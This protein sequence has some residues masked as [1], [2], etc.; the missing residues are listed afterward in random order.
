[1]DTFTIMAIILFIGSLIALGGFAYRRKKREEERQRQLQRLQEQQER[2]RLEREEQ[3]R[4]R[5]FQLALEQEKKRRE[6]L[7]KDTFELRQAYDD[8]RRTQGQGQ[9]A[10]LCTG[11]FAARQLPQFLTAFERAS[12][13]DHIGIILLLELSEDE[14]D[15]C[16][17]NVPTQ[18]LSRIVHP[19][20]E[21][22]PEGLNGARLAKAM[23]RQEDWWHDAETAIN[24]WLALLQH[25]TRTAVLVDIVSPGGSAILAYPATKRF[26]AVYPHA[27]VYMSTI[28]DHKPEVRF[29]FPEIRQLLCQDG[30]V[31]GTILSDNT[32]DSKRNDLGNA[33]FYASAVNAPWIDDQPSS[34]PNLGAHIFPRECHCGAAAHKY[35][36]MSVAGDTIPV[37]YVPEW[38]HVLPFVHYTKASMAVASIQ[39][40]IRT[41]FE[42]PSLQSVPLEPVAPGHSRDIY[43]SA[44]ILPRHLQDVAERVRDNMAGYLAA[45]DPH[46]SLHF[47]SIGVELTPTDLQAPVIA[48]LVQ[49]LQD[50]GEALDALAVGNYT[51]AEKFKLENL[52]EIPV[53]QTTAQLPP[54]EGEQQ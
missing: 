15:R 22:C 38:E 54:P 39:R 12:A 30:L 46:V 25:D 11:T 16:L 20:S 29:R 27:P 41:V 14:R 52:R 45:K 34:L 42:H 7:L 18:F 32:R 10:V 49:A 13:E 43:V 44:P 17:R 51:V 2:E 40:C 37:Y 5:Q 23:E 53:P 48:V 50:D 24:R 6:E 21:L 35:A 4:Q 26:R 19:R 36:T 3:E 9:V 8:W 1:M 47:A 28:I 33:L 31:T